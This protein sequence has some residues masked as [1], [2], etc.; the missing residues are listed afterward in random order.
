MIE[1]RF[2]RNDK[3]KVFQ[4]ALGCSSRKEIISINANSSSIYMK[5]KLTE[6]INIIDAA[7]WF[8]KENI[9]SVQLMKLNIEGG[10]YELL[11]RL[12]ETGLIRI[13]ENIQVQFHNIERGSA[14]RM[15][16]IQKH[17]KE[18]H[19]PTYKYKFVWENYVRHIA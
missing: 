17:L 7:E 18:T 15:E 16:N 3:I 19:T 6:E 1:S 10:E 9:K 8:K 4:Y 2:Q 13:I 14:D 11:E 12:I 5:S